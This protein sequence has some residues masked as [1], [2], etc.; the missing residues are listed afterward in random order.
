[1]G[2]R[3]CQNDF[4]NY[5]RDERQVRDGSLNINFKCGDLE[6][7]LYHTKHFKQRQKHGFGNLALA[8]FV[9]KESKTQRHPRRYIAQKEMRTHWK[10][11]FNSRLTIFMLHATFTLLLHLWH[12]PLNPPLVFIFAHRTLPLSHLE[13]RFPLGNDSKKLIRQKVMSL[14]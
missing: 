8:I 3:W 9:R 2:I 4:F 10:Q 14:L 5:F 13:S 7:W 6:K 12:S 11:V 1:M